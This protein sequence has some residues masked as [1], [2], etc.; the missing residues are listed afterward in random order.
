MHTD[1]SF[2]FILLLFGA[3]LASNRAGA[4]TPGTQQPQEFTTNIV[5]S[6]VV[7]TVSMKYLLYLPED[8]EKD[9]KTRWPLI[10][11]LHGAGERG[12]DV[13][14]LKTQ[15]PPK[16]V[17]QGKDFPFIIVS[18]QCP[19]KGWW[20]PVTLG[21]LL[22]TVI[23]N[24]RVDEDRV[25]ATGM[26]MG[27]NGTWEMAMAYPD[28]FAA[29]APICS[30]GDAG[31]AA[32]VKHVAA[33][34]FH[35][36]KDT[37]IKIGAG[38]FIADALKKAGGDV[39]FTSYPDAGHDSWTVTYENPELYKWFLDHK[40]RKPGTMTQTVPASDERSNLPPRV[41]TNTAIRIWVDQIGWRTDAKKVAIIASDHAIPGIL[42]IE[43]VNTENGKAVWK[44]ADNPGA[45][46]N[47]KSGE[48]DALSGDI[49][50]H[51]D[52]SDFKAPGRYCFTIGT[53]GAIERSCAFNIADKVYRKPAL[54]SWKAIYYNRTDCEI[55]EQYG[56]AWNHKLNG[57]H[58]N[59][60]RE[61]QVYTCGNDGGDDSRRWGWPEHPKLVSDKRYDIHGGWWNSSGSKFMGSTSDAILRL[62]LC[63]QIVGKA[64]KDVVLNLP[65]AGDGT[66]PDM[67]NEIRWGTDFMLRFC[68][69][70]GAGFTRVVII[71]ASPPESWDGPYLI[72]PPNSL[73]TINRAA[74]LAYAALVWTE[75]NLEPSYAMK[76]RDE[77]IRAWS[78]LERKPHPW[79][80]PQPGEKAIE[81][82]VI[83]GFW[84][85]MG[86][87]EA[88]QMTAAAALFKLTGESKYEDVVRRWFAGFQPKNEIG[89]DWINGV[90]CY[91]HN[92]KADQEIV[93][94]MKE[95]ILA[96]GE[97]TVRRSG[98]NTAYSAGIPGYGYGSNST[99]GYTG[100]FAVLA[101]EVCDNAAAKQ[102]YLDAAEDY[103]HYLYGRNP[104]GVCYVTNL[105]GHGAENSCMIMCHCWLGN[106][107]ATN[108][109]KY[110]GDGPGRIGPPPGYVT[111]G[112]GPGSKFADN[113][114]PMKKFTTVNGW[115]STVYTEP[116]ISMQA[117][118]A[119]LLAYFGLNVE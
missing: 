86:G 35:G 111:A 42:P 71:G 13:E 52:F 100:F 88:A 75:H 55:P 101:A 57:H 47:F 23:K 91:I 61:A 62:L 72:L 25:Y 7:K 99:I 109:V 67:L 5:T 11:F 36:E 22:E 1:L 8:Y 31:R 103:V 10:L 49:V 118:C 30:W 116:L 119:A 12:D 54:E 78:L 65:P 108:S 84:W 64:G 4:Q 46:K 43:L 106:A 24:N 20:S 85:Y 59:Q 80:K 113:L 3:F 66:L 74:T 53:N 32:L 105:R 33:W 81:G 45:L 41:T 6:N 110:L 58:P 98:T 15:G 16:L 79:P 94:K 29:I 56:G 90:W 83:D 96:A 97:A 21:P 82:V 39:K 115:A 19:E 63:Y 69:E 60:S 92:P 34:V 114:P 38:R 27:G 93:R 28:R 48:R 76:C 2:I 95:V 117:N 107:T 73:A 44:L 17:A 50:A 70:D 112:P 26:S 87:Y 9:P 18:P 102:R 77:A 51:L 104:L 37:V 40:R 68:D 89:W 14:K